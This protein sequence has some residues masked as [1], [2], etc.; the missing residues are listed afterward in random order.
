VV[1]PNGTPDWVVEGAFGEPAAGCWVVCVVMII[2]Y[3]VNLLR[4][5][6][7]CCGLLHLEVVKFYSMLEHH[8]MLHQIDLREFK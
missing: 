3:S 6:G 8:A 1:E 4:L 2:V 5:V 7:S